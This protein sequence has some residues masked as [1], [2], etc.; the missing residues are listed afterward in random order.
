MSEPMQN[1]PNRE[2]FRA[3]M[4]ELATRL[5]PTIC[6]DYR[7]VDQDDDDDTPTMQVTVGCE[8]TSD[9]SVSWSYQ[10]GDNS[11]SGGAYGYAF[12]GIGY[13][14]RDTSPADFANEIICS[15]E[16]NEEFSFEVQ[17]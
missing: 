6:D 1:I 15:L 9:D 13:L 17:S 7:T 10:T 4:I 8:I 14:T 3:D 16:D 5:I 11:F 2:S 12:W